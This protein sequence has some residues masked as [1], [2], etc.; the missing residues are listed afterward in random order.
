MEAKTGANIKLRKLSG[1]PLSV[2]I[3]D[4]WS[5]IKAQPLGCAF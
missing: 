1:Y 3:I 5:E 4:M 2:A